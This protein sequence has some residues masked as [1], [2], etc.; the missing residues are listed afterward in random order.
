MWFLYT[1]AALTLFVLWYVS[2][3]GR[4]W[5]KKQSW[6]QWYYTSPFAE[7]V[8]TVLFSKSET[9]LYAR[10]KMLLA[11][12]WQGVL[13]VGAVDPTPF[14]IFVP[15]KYHAILLALPSI[16]L[17]LDSVM[18]EIQRRWTTKP[19]PM[20]AVPE[21]TP[22]SQELAEKIERA[23]VAKAEVVAEIKAAA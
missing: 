5:L 13:A 6:M 16:V 3:I 11:A 10:F 22:I 2:P 14:L 7:R 18:G 9:I 17:A 12:A 21:T 23:D 8:E 1:I 4:E 20:V 19:L 15:Q